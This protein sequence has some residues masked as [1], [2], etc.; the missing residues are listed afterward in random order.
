MVAATPRAPVRS[1]LSVAVAFTSS[2]LVLPHLTPVPLPEAGFVVGVNLG[3]H[4]MIDVGAGFAYL[5]AGA[6][7]FLSTGDIAPYLVGR[8]GATPWTG[9]FVLGGIGLD[10]SRADGTYAYMEGG[11]L[12]AHSGST[13]DGATPPPAHWRTVDVEATFGYGKRF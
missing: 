8:V 13:T 7:L 5:A 3:S 2:L 9:E 4:L 12:L 6:K 11:P 10:V 1:E